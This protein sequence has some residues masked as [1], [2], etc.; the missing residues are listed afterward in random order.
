MSDKKLINT[1][2]NISQFDNFSKYNNI[3]DHEFKDKSLKSFIVSLKHYKPKNRENF[4]E[5]F[6][7][8]YPYQFEEKKLIEDDETIFGRIKSSKNPI[9]NENELES[10]KNKQM[11]FHFENKKIEIEGPDS[12]RYNPNYDSIFKKIPGFKMGYKKKENSK[13]ISGS[14]Q[15]LIDLNNIKMTELNK[16]SLKQK[17][18]SDSQNK[19]F[20]TNIKI[21]NT[22][23]KKNIKIKKDILLNLPPISFGN[24][25]KNHDSSKERYNTIEP[26]QNFINNVLRLKKYKS[27]NIKSHKE[28]NKNIMENLSYNKNLLINNIID[29]GKMSSRNDKYLINAYSLDVPSSEK[30]TP[31]YNFIEDN[32]KNIIFSRFGE[33]KVNKKFLLKKLISSYKVPTEYQFIDNEKLTKDKDFINQQLILKYNIYPSK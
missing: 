18:A 10:K 16:N 8:K 14:N 32:I 6:Y 13:N 9:K 15:H 33:N 7:K 17:N 28:N 26:K 27:R 5:E 25:K 20:K 2:E 30:Y 31:K 11:Q 23:D 19:L 1:F 3:L 12:L 22:N 21:N 24:S 29:F 4:I